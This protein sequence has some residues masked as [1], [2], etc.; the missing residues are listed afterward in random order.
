MLVHPLD[1]K[2]SKDGVQALRAVRERIPDLKVSLFG[3]T[4]LRRWRL[5]R[6][7]WSRAAETEIW[8]SPSRPEVAEILRGAAAYV[9]PSWEEGFGL[10][11][12]E[13]LLCGAALATTDARGTRDY[14]IDGQTALVSPPKDPQALAQ[15][16]ERL[17][18]NPTFREELASRGARYVD[19]R[20][21][22]WDSTAVQIAD[23]LQLRV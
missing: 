13:A 11:G 19:Q 9:L 10:P 15:N 12:L 21:S 14:A 23:W 20:F 17:I 4:W 1:S 5:Q 6:P 2:G 3:R 22:G 16:I 18:V 8:K 7:L